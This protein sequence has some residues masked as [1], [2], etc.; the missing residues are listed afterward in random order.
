MT[1]LQIPSWPPW[2]KA[3]EI[4]LARYVSPDAGKNLPL[5]TTPSERDSSPE[6]RCAAAR[7]IYDGLLQA[8]IR[9]AW[10]EYSAEPALQNIRRPAEI[11]DGLRAGTCLDLALLFCGICLTHELRPLLIVIEG[12][13]LAAVSLDSGLRD[14][15]ADDELSQLCNGPLKDTRL[16]RRLLQRKALLAIECTG[17]AFS[18]RLSIE[19]EDWPETRGR[20]QG[21]MDF[22]R[23]IAAGSEQVMHPSRPLAFALDIA[24]LQHRHKVQPY[25]IQPQGAVLFQQLSSAAA[26]LLPPIRTK[27]FQ[28][29][30]R[31]RTRHFVGRRFVFD[32]IDTLLGD[33]NF[34]SG[35]IV[36]RGEPGIGKSALMS[37]LVLRGGYVHHFNIATAGITSVRAFLENVCAQLIVRY[38]LP[39]TQ[40]PPDASKDGGFLMQLLD[41]AASRSNDGR[42]VIVVDAL[43]EVDDGDMPAS[44]NRLFLPEHLPAGVFFIVSTRN[45]RDYQLN[46]ARPREIAIQRD[47][48]ENR[49]DIE[50]FIRREIA[51]APLQ[52]RLSALADIDQEKFVTS[53]CESSEGNF[54]YL[55]HVLRDLAQ[56]NIAV[57]D[58]FDNLP[59]GLRNYYQHHWRSMAN[60]EGS[61][62]FAQRSEPVLRLLAAAREPVSAGKLAQWA[63]SDTTTIQR[64]LKDWSEFLNESGNGDRPLYRIYHKAFRDFLSEEGEGLARAHEAITRGPLDKIRLFLDSGL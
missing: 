47:A 36:I 49:S 28:S 24:T 33:A 25:P 39:Y 40:L 12:H 14:W 62:R 9:Y 52:Q 60:R 19:S 55:V 1:E 7:E 48:V 38:E 15:E 64:V 10:E 54:M 6:A 59:R 21:T 3:D 11:L 31:E 4:G 23:A 58:A 32:S 30:I 51:E 44:A 63:N 13:A 45:R 27:A 50:A 37:E 22:D 61:E 42:V 20:N 17:F 35:Y 5:S 2:P 56:G 26:P 29:F 18:N 16:L 57:I 34:P 53:L 46:V 43:D 41:E 8:N